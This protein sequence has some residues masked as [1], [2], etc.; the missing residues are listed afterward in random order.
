MGVGTEALNPSPA[1]FSISQCGPF[2]GV[3][4]ALLLYLRH[5]L[6]ADLVRFHDQLECYG[7]M[8]ACIGRIWLAGTVEYFLQPTLERH[9][10]TQSNEQ[11]S[12]ISEVYEVRKVVR[13]VAAIFACQ[14]CRFWPTL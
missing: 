13:T 12:T 6:V 7:L 14:A 11:V 2:L 3:L 8:V 1:L 9:P 5:L 10:R 4:L